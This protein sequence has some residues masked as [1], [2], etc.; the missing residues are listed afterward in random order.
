MSQYKIYHV[1]GLMSGSSLDGLD[2][3]HCMFQVAADGKF[4]IND[5]EIVNGT[6][7]PYSEDWQD[8]LKEL[9]DGSALD[10]AK[11]DGQFG[12]Y[13]GELVNEYV[14]ESGELFDFIA[15]HGHTI[16][17][18]PQDGFT[19]QIGNGAAIAAITG[20]DTICD[21]RSVDIALGGQGAPVVGIADK[22]LFSSYELLLNLGGICNLTKQYSKDHF[23]FDISVCNQVLNAVSE[24]LGKP[25]DNRGQFARSGRPIK[26]ILNQIN[27][28][29]FFKQSAPKSL[30]NQWVANNLTKPFVESYLEPEDLLATAVEHIAFQIY[31]AVKATQEEDY[32]KTPKMMITGGGAFNDFLVDR[33]KFHC[34]DLCEVVLPE[35]NI[36]KYKEALLMGLMGVMR[37]LE[38]PNCIPNFTGAS[39]ANVGG[40]IYKG[41]SK[42]Q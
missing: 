13:M 18:Y 17:H 39:A 36:I 41:H 4:A 31:N 23:S 29:P 19:T 3:A 16:F 30:D 37:L 14:T 25:Y 5:W 21:F 27:L 2:I 11:A 33:I 12:K 10:L 42:H 7:I 20:L 8:R 34:Q 28:L 26:Q 6:T 22:H 1:L 35:E 38:V 40:T 32:F 24:K 9:P 15:S